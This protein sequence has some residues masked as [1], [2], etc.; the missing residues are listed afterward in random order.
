MSKAGARVF[1][2]VMVRSGRRVPNVEMALVPPLVVVI[3]LLTT[4]AVAGYWLMRPTVLNNPGVAVYQPPAAKVLEYGSGAKL[5]EIELAA[6]AAALKA[7]EKFGF[8]P[9][10]LARAKSTDA[11][12]ERVAPKPKQKTRTAR[13]QKR[14]DGSWQNQPGMAWPLWPNQ[15]RFA[16]RPFRMWAN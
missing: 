16:Q 13:V 5:A 14:Q 7:N 15:S 6:N 1:W 8:Q 4:F 3:G 9:A 11:V 12:D 2:C 10:L